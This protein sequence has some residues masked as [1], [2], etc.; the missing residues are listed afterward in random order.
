MYCRGDPNDQK[1]AKS[2]P[3]PPFLEGVAWR[4]NMMNVKLTQLERM[5]QLRDILERTGFN[6]GCHTQ[7]NQDVECMLYPRKDKAETMIRTALNDR[8]HAFGMKVN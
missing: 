1:I 5:F 7:V 4:N 6:P 2:S 8:A 3:A